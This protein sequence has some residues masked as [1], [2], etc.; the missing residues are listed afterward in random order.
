LPSHFKALLPKNMSSKIFPLT[1]VAALFLGSACNNN[2][3]APKALVLEVPVTQVLQQDIPLLSEFTGQTLGEA[4]VQ[5][6]PRVSGLIESMNFKEGSF[7]KKDQ[8]LYTVEP[9]TYQNNVNVAQANLATAKTNLAA[10]KSDFERIDALA[11]MNAVSLRELDA[12]RAKYEASQGSESSAEAQLRNSQI[13]LGYCSITS[14]IDGIIG[15][16]KVQVGDYVSPGPL[17]SINTV[18]A[19]KNIRVRFTLSEQEFLRIY[20]ESKKEN[21][22]LQGGKDIQL[23]LSDGSVYEQKGT[24]SFANRE[25]DPSTGAITLEAL[26]PN[27]DQLLR[28]GQYVKVQVAAEVRKKVLVIPQ[29]SVIEMQGI[30]QVY[31]LGDSNKVNMQIIQPGPSFKDAYIVEDGLKAGDKIAFGGTNLLKNGSVIAPKMT[32]WEPGMTDKKSAPAK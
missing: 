7:V 24:F 16:S 10:A 28:P 17:K 1:I 11:K 27:P 4:D 23:E 22:S 18:S 15:I 2:K 26:F 13:D 12:A 6:A 3:E 8:L 14:P 9:L 19:T 32:E 29:R 5:I 31:V 20:R 30:Y 25:V 21:S